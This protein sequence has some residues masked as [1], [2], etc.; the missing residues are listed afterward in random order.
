MYLS[1]YGLRQPP[2][3][4]TPDPAFFFKGSRRGAVLD[5][6]TYAISHGEGIIKVTG[7]VGSGKT[8]LCRMLES[9][10]PAHIEVIWL[11]NPTVNRDDVVCAI[12]A[13]LGLETR[14]QRM[15]QIIRSLQKALIERHAAGKQVV[16][17]VE[18]AQ[19]M[20]LAT[21]EEIRLLS[22]LE[23]AHAK[24]LQIVLFGQ[25]ELNDHL[26]LACMRQLCERI[27]HS[28][29]IPPMEAALVPAYLRF[30][31]HAAGYRG[32]DVFSRQATW[33]LIRAAKGSV[34]RI[35]VLADK[36]LL[37]AFADNAHLVSVKHV[38]MAI[39]DS[40][41]TGSAHASMW[42][43]KLGFLVTAIVLLSIAA[44]PFPGHH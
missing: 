30:R 25:Q 24:L 19:A 4:L 2:F 14:D 31:M 3:S 23:T 22:N 9:S 35:S 15:H 40:K 37:A 26:K 17:L 43:A 27:T 44:W 42:R 28:F 16:L 18:E 13:E 34:R 6:L 33:R 7:E 29:D 36:S 20:P 39:D 5:A 10:L 41:I 32:P 8:M 38:S 21:L 1:H 11:L 12:A